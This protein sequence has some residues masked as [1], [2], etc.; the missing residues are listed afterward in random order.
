MVCGA[1]VK[2][3]HGSLIFVLLV[4][5]VLTIALKLDIGGVNVAI[6]SIVALFYLKS[7]LPHLFEHIGSMVSALL[8][9]LIAWSL[10]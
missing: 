1:S 4:N 2:F 7:S 8:S 5:R 9:L 6:V 3:F 10:D